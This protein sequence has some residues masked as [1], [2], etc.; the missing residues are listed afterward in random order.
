MPGDF[1]VFPDPW[2]Q[3]VTPDRWAPTA[4][5]DGEGNEGPRETLEIRVAKES[6]ATKALQDFQGDQGRRENQA[7]MDSK[8]ILV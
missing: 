2:E 3:K 7:L 6:E 5:R 8:A 1:L 4:P